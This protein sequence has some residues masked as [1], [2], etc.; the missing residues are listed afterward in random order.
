MIK[1][2]LFV[3]DGNTIRIRSPNYL[4]IIYGYDYL[5]KVKY[6]KL[7]GQKRINTKLNKSIAEWQLGKKLLK[8][9]YKDISENNS[10]YIDLMT[11]M[12]VETNDEETI[13]P[14]L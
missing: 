7:L 6:E 5:E 3:C 1:N 11:K 4:T 8:I 13:D 14:R 10:H 2:I 12:I 9:P